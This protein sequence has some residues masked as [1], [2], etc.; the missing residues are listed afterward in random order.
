MALNQ[1]D[2]SP[3]LEK[4]CPNCG[5]LML[6]RENSVTFWEKAADKAAFRCSNTNCLH[7]ITLNNKEAELLALEQQL[8]QWELSLES[9]SKEN[10]EEYELQELI[11][12]L[13]KTMR[14]LQHQPNQ[15]LSAKGFF[16]QE[17]RKQNHTPHNV[18]QLL[19][20]IIPLA[21]LGLTL[22]ALILL[23]PK[24]GELLKASLL[25][26]HH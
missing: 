13:R 22:I 3:V 24:V 23:G 12:C 18:Q 11:H 14:Y 21:A 20:T 4:Q 7:K 2:R 5:A 19:S 1:I 26:L 16:L 6:I 9:L 10:A 15:N 8:G 17:L 25:S